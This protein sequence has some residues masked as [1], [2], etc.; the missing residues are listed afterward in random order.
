MLCCFISGK[1]CYA[2]TCW[3]GIAIDKLREVRS[4]WRYVVIGD[5]ESAHTDNS[6]VNIGE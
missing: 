1:Y 6:F 3:K 5:Q 2:D 4:Y